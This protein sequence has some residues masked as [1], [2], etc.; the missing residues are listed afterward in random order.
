L[1]VTSG[2]RV[3]RVVSIVVLAILVP[4][5]V[6]SDSIGLM[7]FT[8]YSEQRSS[9]HCWPHD[10]VNDPQVITLVLFGGCFWGFI[11]VLYAFSVV[12]SCCRGGNDINAR[13]PSRLLRRT[14][15]RLDLDAVSSARGNMT[16][17]LQSLLQYC[18]AATCDKE[19]S[20]YCS[21]CQDACQEGQ[22]IR[23][24]IACGHQYHDECL[25]R[26]LQSRPVCPNCQQD[27]TTPVA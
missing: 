8:G 7:W 1:P 12:Y 21:I 18:P 19:C 11:Y 13:D 5:F 4:A 20:V 24:I 26:W 9:W 6:A 23:T 25:Q 2:T 15:R 27:V 22:E 3:Q 17:P 10:V 16:V 14:G